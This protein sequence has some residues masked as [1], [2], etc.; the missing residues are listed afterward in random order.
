MLNAL[1]YA[2]S[3]CGNFD[4]LPAKS[5]HRCAA[6]MEEELAAVASSIA[7]SMPFEAAAIEQARPSL[8]LSL[9][10]SIYIYMYVCI[11]IYV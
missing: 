9:Y 8:S 7:R 5:M 6:A 1:E 10:L 11:Y 2:L 4:A 3:F